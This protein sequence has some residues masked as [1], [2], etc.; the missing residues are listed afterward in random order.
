MDEEE[1]EEDEEEEQED[2]N[3]TPSDDKEIQEVKREKIK[4]ENL[5][6][7]PSLEG[8]MARYMNHSCFPNLAPI[9]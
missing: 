2:S 6:V 5:Y 4:K 8:N 1:V 9:R 3:D 7:D